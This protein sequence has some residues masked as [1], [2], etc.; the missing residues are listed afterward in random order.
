MNIERIC[1][2]ER[3]LKACIGMGKEEFQ[4]LLPSFSQAWSIELKLAS[5]HRVRKIG[6]GKKGV[7]KTMEDKLFAILLYLK[8]YPL[9]KTSFCSMIR[10]SI[11]C[12]L[13]LCPTIIYVKIQEFL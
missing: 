9:E 4:R 3:Q 10:P 12:I 13:S 8:T 11:F 7:L 1:K 5:P 2:D 6:G